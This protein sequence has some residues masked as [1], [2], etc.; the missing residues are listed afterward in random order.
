[1]IIRSLDLFAMYIAFL[2]VLQ[3]IIQKKSHWQQQKAAY[4]PTVRYTFFISKQCFESRNQQI[5]I[6]WE[7]EKR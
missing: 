3:Y 2:T 6:L 5:N 4:F 7:K 1:M